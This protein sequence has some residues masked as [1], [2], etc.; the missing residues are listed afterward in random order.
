MQEKLLEAE[1]NVTLSGLSHDYKNAVAYNNQKMRIA[2][3]DHYL[4]VC[5]LRSQLELGAGLV[6]DMMEKR[7]LVV[8]STECLT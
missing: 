7:C 6:R 8:C 3:N 4:K 2:A 5:H 1:F